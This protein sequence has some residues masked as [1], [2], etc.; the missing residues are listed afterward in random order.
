MG[1]Q[2]FSSPYSV[3][4]AFMSSLTYMW[5]SSGSSSNLSAA[6]STGRICFVSSGLRIC[7]SASFV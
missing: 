1:N 7:S 4:L 2:K 6:A 3:S 5:V